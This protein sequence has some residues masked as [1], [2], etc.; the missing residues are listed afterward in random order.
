M[1]HKPPTLTK[2]ALIEQ[3]NA[4]Y[5]K[6]N[7]DSRAA[8][9]LIVSA[10]NG[11]RACGILIKELMGRENVNESC[12]REWIQANRG[13]LCEEEVAWLMNA[14]RVSN[15]LENQL[16][17]FGDAPI[18]VLQMTLQ[19][20]GLL[21]PDAERDG[22]QTSHQLAPAAQAWKYFMDV[23]VKFDA[24]VKTSAEWDVS[25]KEEVKS[26][27]DKTIKFLEELGEKL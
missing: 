26:S 18:S 17:L 21:P 13:R 24:M 3:F 20:A 1:S 7:S 14:V 23:R 25:A 10:I 15:K 6:A 19:C 27:I 9:P 2:D 11:Q 5:P 12:L 4:I 16:E 8:A 22:I